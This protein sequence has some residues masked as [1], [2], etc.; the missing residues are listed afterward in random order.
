LREILAD[1]GVALVV[2]P[3]PKGCHASGAARLVASDK[4]MILLSF[5]HRSDDQFWFTLFHEIG[6][7]LLHNGRAF[8][9][10]EETPESAAEREANDF[11][12]EC[13]VPTS[14][15][16]EFEQLKTDRDSIVRFAVSVGVSPGLIVG[17]LQHEG[18]IEFGRMTRLK[19]HW[20]WDEIRTGLPAV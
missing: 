6:H 7:L 8:I 17:Q 20:T 10:E 1:A 11:A 13:I 12:G 5:R 14:R 15:S 2:V 9:D 16:H 19:R 4:A 3:A 18:R